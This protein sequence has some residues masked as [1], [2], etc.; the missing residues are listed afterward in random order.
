MS[1]RPSAPARKKT[2]RRSA[3]KASRIRDL[4]RNSGRVIHLELDG[5]RR[6]LETD[7]LLHLELGI[8]V[9]EIVVEHAARFQELAVLV[10]IAERLAQR[11]AH[12]R[13]L[14]ELARGQIV[15]VLVDRRAGIELVL[16]AVETRHQHR[17]KR[18][19]RIGERIGGADLD[20]LALGRGGERN[21]ASGR[22]IAHRIGQQHRRL[23]PGHQALVGIGGRVGEGVDRTRVLRKEAGYLIAFSI[24]LTS[25]ACAPLGWS[26]RY[27][28]N[29]ST[30]PFGTVNLPFESTAPF[31]TITD[32]LTK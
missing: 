11:R 20:A 10:E 1:T 16:D 17:R 2:G 5:M 21:A 13:D 8:G 30:V 29:V 28:F 12:G 7:D 32:P 9:E 14:L 23:E 18:K 6:V 22:A 24:S 19:I 15:E 31:P 26:S 4:G 3:P 27:F 25:D